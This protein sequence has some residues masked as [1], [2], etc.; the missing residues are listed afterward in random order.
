M[1]N[2]VTLPIPFEILVKSAEASLA[3]VIPVDVREPFAWVGF[4]VEQL[5]EG[6]QVAYKLSFPD[7]PDFGVIQVIY[8][9]KKQSHLAV[10]EP[11]P[12][13]LFRP[14]DLSARWFQ[15]IRFVHLPD[16]L[17]PVVTSAEPTT[18]ITCDGDYLIFRA[19]IY[20]FLVELKKILADQNYKL[21]NPPRDT[22]PHGAGWL[23]HYFYADTQGSSLPTWFPTT[24]QKQKQWKK[25]YKFIDKMQKKYRELFEKRETKKPAPGIEDIRDMLADKMKWTPERRTIDDIKRA[26]KMGLFDQIE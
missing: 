22:S 10:I 8:F 20:S 15:A 23:I 18:G 11:A 3:V 13:E 6:A 2:P 24:T 9:N 21:P 5:D 17:K 12:L 26:G 16:S 4:A 7:R 14:L 19:V 1:V 25:A